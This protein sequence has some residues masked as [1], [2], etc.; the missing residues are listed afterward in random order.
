MGQKRIGR[1]GKAIE[2]AAATWCA[3]LRP[4]SGVPVAAFSPIA[5]A[6]KRRQSRQRRYKFTHHI[7]PSKFFCVH[8]LRLY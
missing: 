8:Y 5:V 6:S 2:A 7:S 1:H 3:R 4:I